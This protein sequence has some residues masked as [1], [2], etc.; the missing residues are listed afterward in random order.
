MALEQFYAFLDDKPQ[1]ALGPTVV[2]GPDQFPMLESSDLKA[3]HKQV[4]TLIEQHRGRGLEFERTK[5]GKK[6]LAAGRAKRTR[7]FLALLERLFASWTELTPESDDWRVEDFFYQTGGATDGLA[8]LLVAG[9]DEAQVLKPMLQWASLQRRIHYEH[10]LLDALVQVLDGYE[11]ADELRPELIAIRSHLC[12]GDLYD[13]GKALLQKIDELFGTGIWQIVIPGEF[14]TDYAIAALQK[15]KRVQRDAWFELLAH[16]QKA[17]SAKPSPKWEK[18]LSPL[19]DSVGTAQF[20]AEVT[21]WFELVDKGR[22]IKLITSRWETADESQRIHERNADLLRGLLWTAASAADANVCRA[23]GRVAMSAYR[24]ARGIGPRAVKVGNAAVYSLGETATHDALG[25]LA[26]LK[27]KVKFGTAQKGIDKALTATA[28]RLGVPREDV[29]EMGVPSYGLTDVGR[30]EEPLG[31][32][33]ARLTVVGT[34]GTEL[35]WIKPD[36]KT[37]KSVPAAVKRDHADDLK[38]LKAAAKD[39]QKMLPAQRDR[40]D[41]LF[42]EQKTWPFNVWRERYL[43]HPLVGTI[44]RRIIWRFTTGKKTAD[45]I[46]SDGELVGSD[47][48]PIKGLGAKTL[49]ELWHPIDQPL[50]DVLAWRNWLEEHKVR[51]P[52]KQA[53]REVYLLTDAERNTGIY[54]NRYASHI[55]RQHQFNA[56]CG[57]RGWKNTLRLM[58]DDS[59]PPATRLLSKWNLRA[60]FWVEGAGDEYGVDTNETGTYLY[61]ATDQVHFYPI[62]ATQRYAHAGGGGY[63]TWGEEGTDN[64]IPL[65]DI[66]PLVFS[67]IMRDV[68]LFVGVASVGNDPNWAD[69]GPEGRYVDYWQSYS[70]GDLSATAQTRKDVLERLIPRLKIADRCSFSDKFLVVKGDVRTYK[71]HLGSSNILMEPND[72]YL[73][74]VPARGAKRGKDDVFLPFEGDERLSIILSKAFLLAD[75]TKIKDST[76]VSQIRR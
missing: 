70:F 47:N 68:D 76:I 4:S 6:L 24:K 36:G 48:K 61:L 41:G 59:Y 60:E 74:I 58:V 43:D 73:C 37:Q 20:R 42:L 17:K 23:M 8:A 75:D 32:F 27:V 38:E 50:D 13:P 21:K 1:E 71:I 30:L 66:P 5:E 51:Q 39:I 26:Y 14:W 56:L 62:D 7:L 65:T 11:S 10:E 55:V 45:G 49:V 72:E 40:I 57:A 19:L 25:Q 54:S 16:C 34:G 12:D 2:I 53:H 44:A 46:F 64:P 9:V 15:M 31:E 63:E 22:S 69:G 35:T 29:E 67:E 33:T 3:E 52:F 18:E 28:E